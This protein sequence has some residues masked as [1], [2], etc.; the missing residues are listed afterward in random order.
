MS[1][2]PALHD[3]EKEDEEQESDLDE[4][5]QPPVTWR[6]GK[7][8]VHRDALQYILIYIM[9]FLISSA[10]IVNISFGNTPQEMW[11]SILSL[12][13]GVVVPQPHSSFNPKLTKLSNYGN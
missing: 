9:L 13:I 11:V 6:L 5:D 12:V 8:E 2:I 4:V 1:E 3:G 7:L 10:A